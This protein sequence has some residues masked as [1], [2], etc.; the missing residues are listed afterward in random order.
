[1]PRAELA[2][3]A[4]TQLASARFWSERTLRPLGTVVAN[5]TISKPGPLPMARAMG[6]PSTES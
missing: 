5:V 1:M 3:M 2:E 6:A 4:A